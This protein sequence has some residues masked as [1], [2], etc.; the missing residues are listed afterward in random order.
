MPLSDREKCGRSQSI[1][2][3]LWKGP[4]AGPTLLFQSTQSLTLTITFRSLLPRCRA[5]LSLRLRTPGRNALKLSTGKSVWS[6][7]RW[8]RAC[9]RSWKKVVFKPVSLFVSLCF[10][11]PWQVRVFAATRRARKER[12]EARQEV[13]TC[14][15]TFRR[16]CEMSYQIK[17]MYDRDAYLK[18][19]RTKS[20]ALSAPA[21]TPRA[22]QQAG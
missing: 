17:R 8:R 3:R 1:F 15:S 9:W 18:T 12:E 14:F 13:Q 21:L 11:W 20:A 22:G 2:P 6:K 7:S 19:D 16:G 5:G 4:T 10:R